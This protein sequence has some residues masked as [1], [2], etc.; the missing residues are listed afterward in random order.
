MDENTYVWVSIR[1]SLPIEPWDARVCDRTS[2]FFDITLP[3]R[4]FATSATYALVRAI[5]MVAYTP[6][7]FILVSVFS[8]CLARIEVH[9]YH[10]CTIRY[11]FACWALVTYP[12]ILLVLKS[13]VPY[14]WIATISISSHVK[15]SDCMDSSSHDSP[16]VVTRI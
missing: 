14:M 16:P 12:C 5:R 2:E 1:D 13:P 15:N 7:R 10:S 11:L 9:P 6:I 4:V 8:W 3:I